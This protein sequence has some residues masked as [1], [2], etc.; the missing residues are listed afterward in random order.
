MSCICL[1]CKIHNVIVVISFICFITV[2]NSSEG[3]YDTLTLNSLYFCLCVII[4]L[5][6]LKKSWAMERLLILS[7]FIFCV[8][9]CHVYVS[10]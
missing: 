9:S 7:Y 1:M 4:I 10:Y 5:Q 6:S 2:S 3:N 8:D